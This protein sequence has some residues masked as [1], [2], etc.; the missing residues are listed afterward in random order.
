MS[1][2]LETLNKAMEQH[3]ILTKEIY[4]KINAEDNKLSC[5]VTG[6]RGFITWEGLNEEPDEYGLEKIINYKTV[7]STKYSALDVLDMIKQGMT[8]EDIE[9]M[10]YTQIRYITFKKLSEVN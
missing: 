3:T 4:D 2:L 9:P 5:F 10:L 7:K 6:K 1:I 8:V